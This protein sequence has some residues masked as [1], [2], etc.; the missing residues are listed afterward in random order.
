MGAAP[1]S[2]QAD[3]RRSDPDGVGGIREAMEVDSDEG[4]EP[5]L[6]IVEEPPPPSPAPA[7]VSLHKSVSFDPCRTVEGDSSTRSASEAIESLLLLGQGEVLRG[8]RSASLC[9]SPSTRRYSS[10][11]EAADNSSAEARQKA[12]ASY[13]QVSLDI[14]QVFWSRQGC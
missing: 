6:A 5:R 11:G 13:Y 7:R 14:E 1:G 3:A 9:S 12:S 2:S 10:S 4:D 8:E